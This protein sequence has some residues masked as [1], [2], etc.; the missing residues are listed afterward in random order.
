[1][2]ASGLTAGEIVAA[3]GLAF[4]S[5]GERVRRLGVGVRRFDN[6]EEAQ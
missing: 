4:L 6:E 1:V 2:V 3:R 5:D